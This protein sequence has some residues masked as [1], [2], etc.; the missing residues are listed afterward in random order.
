MI[1]VI[2]MAALEHSGLDI[3]TCISLIIAISKLLHYSS[4][5]RLLY[6][7]I[8]S[9]VM[10]N[11]ISI[12]IYFICFMIVKLARVHTPCSTFSA[13]RSGESYGNGPER[14]VPG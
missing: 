8:K 13:E 10:S 4:V 1:A 5:L 7:T 3:P 6:C 11:T 2:L 12:C 14:V 9:S